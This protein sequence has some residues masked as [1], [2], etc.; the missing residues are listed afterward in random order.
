MVNLEKTAMAAQANDEPAAERADTQLL[1]TSTALFDRPGL[2][3]SVQYHGPVAVYC[4]NFIVFYT[5]WSGGDGLGW[6]A[7]SV[8]IFIV[9]LA[10]ADLASAMPTAGGLYFW[11]HYFS[12][13]KWKR[14]LSFVVGYSNTI[15]LIGGVCSI[16]YGF[17]TMLLAI[18]SIARDG[19]WS[20]SRPIVYGT[21]VGCVVVHGLIATFFARIM[22]KIQSACIVTNVGLV[23]ATVLALPIGKA[24]NGGTINSGSYVFGQ[25]ENYTTWPSGWAFVLAWLSPI[26]TIGAFDSCVHM[27]EEATNAARAVPLGFLSL[28]VIAAVIN[29]DLEA[30]MGTAF[31]QPMAQIYYDCLGKAGALGFM[32]V[33][34]AVQFFMGL[35][36]VVAASRQSWAFSRDGALPFSSFFRHVSKRIRYQPVRMV[37][38]VV[39]A[40]ITIGLL[41]LI[42]AAASNALFS[43][44]VAG[45]DLAWLMPI[46]CRLVW[47]EDR[48][49]PGVFYTG[50]LSKPI[51]VTAVVYLSFAILLCMFPTL[52]P[53]PNPDDMNYTVVI[54]GALWGGALL[55]YMLYARKTYKGPQ[56]TVHGSSSPSSA[57]STN[58]ERKELESEEKRGTGG[59]DSRDGLK[60]AKQVPN[61]NGTMSAVRMRLLQS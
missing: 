57:A 60:W 49:H 59:G 39:A 5:C 43:L 51:A 54:N 48:F 55:Y 42:N 47:G 21:Y 2:R 24:V 46:L 29:T 30:V 23:V 33:V 19:N 7:A 45:N 4:L 27:S 18:I 12:G 28:A 38:G 25:L 11:T 14:P 53:N 22:P 6:L 26:W 44:A 61:G 58:L 20:A 40:A 31:G 10:M 34:A 9:G 15:G 17:A 1:G 50:R 56:T 36:L 13:E 32:A 52:G 41:C 3:N 8:F 37:W 16:D 35:S